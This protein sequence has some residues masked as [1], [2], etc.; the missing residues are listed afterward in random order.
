MCVQ[1]RRPTGGGMAAW[2]KKGKMERMYK[3]ERMGG[4]YKEI[5]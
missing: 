5:N 4:K 3:K 1:E 2:K